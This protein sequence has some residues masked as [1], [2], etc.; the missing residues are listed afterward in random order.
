MQIVAGEKPSITLSPV[1]FGSTDPPNHALGRRVPVIYSSA[2]EYAI[3]AASHLALEARRSGKGR[4][5]LRE[6]A[7]SEGLPPPFLSTILNT[8]VGAGIL[9]SARGPTGGYELARPPEAITL[10]D[11]KAAVDGVQALD[12]CAVGLERCSD[13]MPCPL[14]ETW[15]PIRERLRTYLHETTLATMADA[16]QGKAGRDPT[17]ASATPDGSGTP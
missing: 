11:I 4:V 6:L 3:R 7:A 13:E 10:Y 15:K 8:L 14:H 9:N 12:A 5:K 16:R 17:S 1:H 2:C